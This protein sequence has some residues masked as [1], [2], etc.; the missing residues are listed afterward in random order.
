MVAI[1]RDSKELCAKILYLGPKFAGKTTNLRSL[2]K[3]SSEAIQTG[4]HHLGGSEDSSAFFDFIP[5]SAGKVVER[6]LKLHIFAFDLKLPLEA[7]R[8]IL[9]TEVDGFVFVADSRLERLLDNRESLELA[10]FFFKEEGYLLSELPHVIQFNKRDEKM[11]IPLSIMS[12]ELN[13]RF[14]PEMESVALHSQG[15][16]ET[17]NLIT[18]QIVD[19]L[20]PGYSYALPQDLTRHPLPHCEPEVRS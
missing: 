9:L 8:K 1:H 15:T 3:L 17:L 2:F 20:V 4:T 5:L 13:P 18:R 16:L 10:H 11:T 12:R 6:D 7:L 19:R 14:A